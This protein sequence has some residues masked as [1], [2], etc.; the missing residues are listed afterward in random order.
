MGANSG[1]ESIPGERY[2]PQAL[3]LA[4]VL[5]CGSASLVMM[6]TENVRW[7][8]TALVAFAI[9]LVVWIVAAAVGARRRGVSWLGVLWM[10]IK[11][12]FRLV[13]DFLP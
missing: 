8:A 6:F 9:A 2:V 11:N 1:G 3:L 10:S 13:F 4:L 7:G 5:I 12:L